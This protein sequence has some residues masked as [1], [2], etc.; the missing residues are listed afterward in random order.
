MVTW[1]HE[2]SLTPRE[3]QEAHEGAERQLAYAYGIRSDL[4]FEREPLD[5]GG[6]RFVQ[7]RKS[8][9]VFAGLK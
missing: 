9:P 7:E 2:V 3:V 1:R 5:D 4:D 8:N 6:V